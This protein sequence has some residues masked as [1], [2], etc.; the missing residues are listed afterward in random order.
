MVQQEIL[1]F[2]DLSFNSQTSDVVAEETEQYSMHVTVY[3][4]N[5]E[6][7]YSGLSRLV[8]KVRDGCASKGVVVLQRRDLLRSRGLNYD[9]RGV[10]GKSSTGISK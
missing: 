3:I 1:L 6:S 7:L 8:F 10:A 5:D 2:S 4:D 9:R